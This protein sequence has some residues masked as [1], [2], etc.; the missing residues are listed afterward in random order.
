[1]LGD[2]YVER[3][4]GV[5]ACSGSNV[6]DVEYEGIHDNEAMVGNVLETRLDVIDRGG[7]T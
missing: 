1:L 3:D 4:E 7:R 5:G 2:G 6:I